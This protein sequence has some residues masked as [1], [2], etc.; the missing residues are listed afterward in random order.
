MPHAT[1]LCNTNVVPTH[2]AS[3]GFRQRAR[4]IL[5]N[6]RSMSMFRGSLWAGAGCLFLTACRPGTPP[7]IEFTEVP[8]ATRG[9]AARTEQIA[10]RAIGARTGQQ[11]VLYAR[12]GTWWVQ[13]FSGRPFTAVG[14]DSSWKSITHLGTEYAAILV[15]PGYSPPKITDV[16]PEKGGKVIAVATIAGRN[17][18]GSESRTPKM[19]QFSGYEWEALQFPTDSGGVAH[20]NLGENVW[21]D[22]AGALHLRIAWKAGEWTCADIGMVRSLGYGSYS[23]AVRDMPVL[24]P[25]TVLGM[26]TW[27][28]AEAGQ[29]HREIDVELSQWGDPEIKNAQYTIQPYYVPANVFRFMSP[30]GSLTHSFRWE[31]GRVSFQTRRASGVIAEHSFT[32]GIPS[33]GAEKVHLNLYIYGKSRTPQQNGV[34]VVIEKFEY[35]P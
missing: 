5:C 31:P 19:L 13:P 11:I 29:N 14:R 12:S 35:L 28:D 21:T 3:W 6:L 8:E 24:E 9:G 23:F 1:D 20:S 17:P 22:A 25:G 15:T 30:S 18:P 10:G 32:S 34:E 16:L 2:S 27:D 26:F 7:S 4:L 33:P